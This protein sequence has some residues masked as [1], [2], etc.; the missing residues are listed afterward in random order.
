MVKLSKN[1]VEAALV[2]HPT[3]GTNDNK[4]SIPNT[5]DANTH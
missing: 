5:L 4:S 2:V 3:L 1:P